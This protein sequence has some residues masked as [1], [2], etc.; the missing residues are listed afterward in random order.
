[1]LQIY[2]IL[3]AL[4]HDS[5]SDEIGSFDTDEEEGTSMDAS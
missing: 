1:M 3:A 5:G 4:K 2:A